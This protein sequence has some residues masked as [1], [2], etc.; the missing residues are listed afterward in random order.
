MN[1]LKVLRKENNVT[2]NKIA[3]LLSINVKTVS[4]WEKGEYEIKPPQARMLAD[5]FRVSVPYLLGNSN[6][7]TEEQA[8]LLLEA[9]NSDEPFSFDMIATKPD[10]HDLLYNYRQLEIPYKN[11]VRKFTRDMGELQKESKNFSPKFP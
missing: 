4:R 8:N 9:N 2:Q 10:E 1:R 7:R 5:Y 11:Q 6:L 3:E